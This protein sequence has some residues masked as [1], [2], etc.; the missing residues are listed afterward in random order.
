[1]CLQRDICLWR[2]MFIQKYMFIEKYRETYVYREISLG[3]GAIPRLPCGLLRSGNIG[4]APPQ[5]D[6]SRVPPRSPF[7][8][9]RGPLS[10]L[11]ATLRPALA[12]LQAELPRRVPMWPWP[13][14]DRV[15][16]GESRGPAGRSDLCAR[17]PV[18]SGRLEGLRLLWS[19]P[20]PIGRIDSSLA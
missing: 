9:P 19:L 7:S 14:R 17:R 3:S 12:P 13:A 18:K 4:E 2:N 10:S 6:R 20:N 11:L 5:E 16:P 15:S 1:M 8:T